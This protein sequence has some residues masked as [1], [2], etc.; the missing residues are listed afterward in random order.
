MRGPLE[1]LI[2]SLK[3]QNDYM[4]GSARELDD[5]GDARGDAAT[6]LGELGDASAVEPLIGTL[7]D[8]NKY[9]QAAAARALGKLGDARALEP[10]IAT[11]KHHDDYVRDCAAKAIACLKDKAKEVRDS[12]TAA[13][14]KLGDGRAVEPLAARLKDEPEVARKEAVMRGLD[15][16]CMIPDRSLTGLE[17]LRVGATT[18]GAFRGL[19]RDALIKFGDGEVVLLGCKDAID[20]GDWVVVRKMPIKNIA[21]VRISPL[22]IAEQV[23]AAFARSL[24]VSGGIALTLFIIVIAKSTGNQGNAQNLGTLVLGVPFG[25]LI[26]GLLFSFLPNYCKLD[27]DLTQILLVT[28]NSQALWLVVK[29]AKKEAALGVFRALELRISDTTA[30]TPSA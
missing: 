19:F 12:A 11:S 14:N 8:Q 20:G 30:T 10:L 21:E 24:V 27:R 15:F 23:K 17:Q 16:L 7:N 9:V 4:R 29:A 2:A 26:L 1:P 3:H 5:L 22:S 18:G 28:S 6:A 25:G 13:L